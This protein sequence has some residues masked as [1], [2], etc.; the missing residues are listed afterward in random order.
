MRSPKKIAR[1]ASM[2]SLL[3]G[4]GWLGVS[5]AVG[6]LQLGQR[7]LA[8]AEPAGPGT[9]FVTV[10]DAAVDALAHA[11]R[12]ASRRQQRQ[13]AWGGTV[14]RVEHGYSYEVPRAGFPDD[15]D[16]VQIALRDRDVAYFTTYPKGTPR[17]NEL[18]ESHS[19]R[20]R[21]NVDEA[22]PRHRP[23]FILT[24]SL[25]VKVYAGS[26]RGSEFVATVLPVSSEVA[27]VR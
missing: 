24:P 6:P 10:E 1:M 21:R 27:S 11:Y 2:G 19:E 7:G 23:S 22:D 17:E 26:R 4:L 12:K 13:R 9:V 18:N 16:S 14:Y 20:D 5:C 25:Q 3:L 15:P 8:P